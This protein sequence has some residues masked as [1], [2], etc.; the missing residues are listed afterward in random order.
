MHDTEKITH[1]NVPSLL[2]DIEN[3]LSLGWLVRVICC[4]KTRRGRTWINWKEWHWNSVVVYGGLG[5]A[6]EQDFQCH[7][8]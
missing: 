2:C 3:D 5:W 8:F 1:G 4:V 6:G 7:P